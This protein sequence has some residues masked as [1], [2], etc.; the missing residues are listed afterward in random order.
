MKTISYISFPCLR[1]GG[2]TS[3]SSKKFMDSS[4]VGTNFFNTKV[5]L[6][7]KSLIHWLLKGLSKYIAQ[8]TLFSAEQ[9]CF[10]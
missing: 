10:P 6:V 4:S 2:S 1:I 8:N 3:C 9:E 5:T 7:N